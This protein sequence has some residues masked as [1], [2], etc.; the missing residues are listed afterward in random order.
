MDNIGTIHETISNG[1]Q[2]RFLQDIA[3]R[4]FDSHYSPTSGSSVQLKKIKR[5][6]NTISSATAEGPRD[7]LR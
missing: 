1:R 3:K 4:S 5:L 6:L 7:A 2:A